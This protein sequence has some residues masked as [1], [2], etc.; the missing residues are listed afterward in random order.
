MKTAFP[1][2][3][4]P[5]FARRRRLL[6]LAAAS[7]GGLA[8]GA[9]SGGNPGTVVTDAGGGLGSGAGGPQPGDPET[10]AQY[11][12]AMHLGTQASDYLETAYQPAGLAHAVGAADFDRMRYEG[13]ADHLRIPANC[14]ARADVDGLISEAFLLVVDKQIQLAL[15]RFPR[16]ILDPLH[17]YLQWKGD[18]AYDYAYD[19]YQRV[20]QLTSAQHA[21]RATA[22]WRQL[23]T[24]YQ[25]LTT[26]L[27]FDLFNEP[28]NVPLQHGYPPGITAAELD[29][30]HA[31]VIPAIRATGGLNAQRMLWMEPWANRLDL[32]ALPADTG[33]HGVSPHYYSPFGFTMGADALTA[34][35]LAVYAADVRYA[36]D[37]A[38]S[39]DTVLWVGETG[40]SINIDVRTQPRDPAQRAE[41]TAH[42]RNTALD[43]GVPIT[44]WGYNSAYAQYDQVAQAWLPGMLQAVSGVPMPLPVRPVPAYQVLTGG[45]INKLF[46][47]THVWPGF[48]YDPASGV[49]TAQANP[50]ASA[51][52][53]AIVFPDIPVASDQTWSVRAT[54]FGGDWRIGSGPFYYDATAPNKSGVPGLDMRG[55]DDQ[56][57]QIYPYLP[58]APGGFEQ[59]Y[60][61][62]ASPQP[63]LAIELQLAAGS[64]GGQIVFSCLRVD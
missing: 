32:L 23:A 34:A 35:D 36:R 58:I 37:W 54:R 14:A 8:L 5:A 13:L 55:V 33:P 62:I 42:V 4:A 56:G 27:A 53:V 59:A 21:V 7:V 9:C 12:S 31:T 10:A 25:G 22:M 17:H 38:V 30:W 44:Y 28:F 57:Q 18:H 24:R 45:R 40:V 61:S 60:G 48:S 19:D 52:G 50:G 47:P 39:R 6:G 46:D 63:F 1:G 15:E 64:P 2:G 41:F 51:W 20:A 29:A 16:V 11:V 43:L 3:P 26:R 49:L